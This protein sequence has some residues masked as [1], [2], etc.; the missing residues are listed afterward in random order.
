MSSDHENKI[1]EDSIIDS[2]INLIPLVIDSFEYNIRQDDLYLVGDSLIDLKGLNSQHLDS[3]NNFYKNGIQQITQAFKIEKDVVNRRSAMPEDKEIEWIHCEVIT[4]GVELKPPTTLHYSTSKEIVLYPKVALAR[5]KVYSGSLSFSCEVKAI[6][7]LKNGSTL[8]R[9][10]IVK[11]FRISKVPIIKGSIMCNTYGK[12]KEALMQMGEDP[13]DPGGYFIVRGEWAVDCTENIT[14]NQPKI[15]VNE[16]YGKSRVRGEFISKPGDTYQNSDMLIIRFYNDDTLTIT[17]LRDKLGSIEIPFYMIFRAMGWTSDK[18]M[19]DWIIYDYESDA[20]KP[21]KNAL[22]DAINAKYNKIQYKDI[23]NQTDVLHSIIDMIPEESYGYLDLKNK[24]ENYHNAITDVLRIFDIHC[25]PHIGLTSESRNEKLKFLGLLVRKVILVYLK[26]IPQT[27]RDSYKNKRIHAAGDNYAKTFKTYFNQTVV[28]PIKRRIIKDFTSSS[29]SQVNLGNLV[30]SAIYADEFERLIVQTIIS[31]N[32]ASLKIKKKTIVNRLATQLLNRKNQLNMIA[33]MR[34]V[35]A[36]SSDSARQSERASEMRRVHMSSIGYICPVHSP[37]EGEKVGINKQMAIFAFIA[38]SSS[39]E[40]L[41][42]IILSDDAIY[43]DGTLTPLEISR[44]SYARVFVNGHLMGYVVDSIAFVNKYRKQRRDLVI[45]PYTTVYWDNVQNEIQ[46]FVDMGRMCRPLMVVFNNKRDANQMKSNSNKLFEQ[47]LGMTQADIIGLY[48]KTKTINDLLKEQKI[49]YITPE[50]QECCYICPNFEQLKRDQ[51]NEFKEYTHCDIPQSILGI[52]ALTAPF[53]NHNNSSKVTYQTTQAKQ[54]CGHYALNW[55]FRMD[56]E[57]FLQYV[58]ETPL[59]R[60]AANKYLFPN[61]LN[62]MVAMAC[63]TGYNQEDSLIVNKSAVERGIFDGSK[64]TYYK[65]EFEQKE[66]LGNPDASKTDGLKSANYEKLHD[67]V[68][69]RGQHISEADVLIG[70]YLPIPKGKDEKYLYMDRSIVYKESEEAIVHNV[71]VDRN[72]DDARFCKVALRKIRPVAIGDKFCL[73]Y[74]SEVLTEN[75]WISL[76]NL[77]IYNTKVATM[78]PITHNLSYVNAI[79]KYEFD[80]DSKV[81]GK[82]YYLKTS[83]IYTVTTP[84]HKH[85]VKKASNNNFQLLDATLCSGNTLKYKRNCNNVFKESNTMILKNTAGVRYRYPMNSYLKLLGMFL[86]DG[87]KSG[88]CIEFSIS[89]QRKK[90]YMNQ[91]AVDMGITFH[92]Y[93]RYFR[94]AKCSIPGIYEEFIRLSLRDVNKKIPLYIWGLGKNNCLAL[95]DGLLNGDGYKDSERNMWKYCTTSSNL[96]ND[97]QKLCL[98][99]G[100]VCNINLQKKIG[101]QSICT[102]KYDVYNLSILHNQEHIP[103]KVSTIRHSEQEEKWIDYQGKVMCIEVP[104]THLFYYRENQFTPAIWTG[105][106]SRHGQKGIAALLMKES[107]MLTTRDGIRPALVF[108]PHGIPSRMTVSQLIDSLIGNLCA[109]K[110]THFDATMFKK[111]DIESIAAE[112]EQ[113]GLHRY[114]Y[115]RMISGLTGEFVD[116]LIFFGP[117]FYQRLQKFVADA[118]YSVR[119]ALTDA[120]TFQPLDG[121]GSAGGLKIGY[122]EK[123]V[124]VSHGSSRFLGEKFYHHSDGFIEY[125]CRCGKPAI[126]NHKENIY[127]CRY[128]KDNADIVAVPTSW[129][130]KLFMQEMEAINVGI[131]RVPRPFSYEVND[132]DEREFSQIDLYNEDTLRELVRQAVDMVDDDGKIDDS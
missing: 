105:N 86:S 100:I 44:G 63:N 70:K 91:I 5:E 104:E 132:N 67:G 114:G 97:I 107:D 25:L 57:T 68:V 95:L 73:R 129:T 8:E 127:K 110:G 4:T 128:C 2:E 35:S 88:N 102:S 130:S 20:N 94:L 45:N 121:Q 19:L 131:R 69:Q 82:M 49:E 24:P 13:S 41:K 58:N 75:G 9:S 47:G 83:H 33:T 46:L 38:P 116:T 118:E 112:L 43:K 120:I 50:E 28:M 122:M 111:V 79:D 117:T 34:Q 123:D 126:V 26:H 42:K 72:E 10:D 66:E 56:K 85:Y 81:D 109:I 87:Y 60:T 36:T 96:S 78:D 52:T 59:V 99:A 93:D 125:I 3:A 119:H 23:Y 30:K 6:A 55:P 12:S 89:K 11:N 113:Y 22:F 1:N 77:D 71:I 7:H 76:K 40:V 53:G 27:D 18:E 90:D 61:G 64:F 17:I 21:L 31:G 15:Y 62:V 14:Y 16:G 106:S 101:K 74:M 92:Y 48:K 51:N 98:H 39:S 124:L 115:E 80:Y 103:E 108:N 37:P 65:T 84:N 54:T 29:F 32:K